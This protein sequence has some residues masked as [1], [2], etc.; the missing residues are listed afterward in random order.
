MSTFRLCFS[1]VLGYLMLAMVGELGFDGAKVCWLLLL[2]FLH[3][4]LAICLSLVLTCL[5]V[6]VWSLPPVSLVTADLL[7]DLHTVGC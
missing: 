6:S 4:P 5:S 7:G 1:G 2:M 3:L